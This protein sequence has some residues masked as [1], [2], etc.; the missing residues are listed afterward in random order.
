[1]DKD[2][3]DTKVLETLLFIDSRNDYTRTYVGSKILALYGLLD[4][5]K[6]LLSKDIL[7]VCTT[8]VR[9]GIEKKAYYLQPSGTKLVNDYLIGQGYMIPEKMS[10]ELAH[11]SV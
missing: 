2:N 11:H 4:T 6:E 9:Q 3:I 1:M 5:A 8:S 7:G 10:A